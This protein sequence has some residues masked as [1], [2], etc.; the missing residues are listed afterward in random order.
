MSTIRYESRTEYRDETSYREVFSAVYLKGEEE[1]DFGMT[2]A[3]TVRRGLRVAVS[4]S[5]IG[6]QDT[7]TARARARVF[8]LAIRRAEEIESYGP[9][10]WMAAEQDEAEESGERSYVRDVTR[11]AFE[12][13]PPRGDAE[14]RLYEN[15]IA[16]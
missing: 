4:Q 1:T 15:A 5:A 11:D 6:A 7:E 8:Q 10:A 9:A 16:G 14:V 2:A 3:V 13:I 12:M